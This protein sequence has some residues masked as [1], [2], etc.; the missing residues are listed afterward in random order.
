MKSIIKQNTCI[1]FFNLEASNANHIIQ[2]ES[3]H[4]YE[5]SQK[6]VFLFFLH[7]IV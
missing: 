7:S 2:N 6:P 4:M 5:L 3:I 1:S